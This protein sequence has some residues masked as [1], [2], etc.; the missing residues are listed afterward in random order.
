MDTYCRKQEIVNSL[1]HSV[2]ILFGIVSIPF[3]LNTAIEHHNTAGIIGSS[4]YGICYLM[5]FTSST[6]YHFCQDSSKKQVF[7]IF[8]HISIYFFIAGTYTPFLLVFMNNPLGR[9]LLC[10]LWGLTLFGI[11]WKTY[12]TGKYEI[13]STAV[14]VLMGWIMLVGGHTFFAHLPYQVLLLIIIGAGLYTVGVFFY[15]WD[16]YFYTH[17]VWHG[18]VLCAA[19]FHYVAVLLTVSA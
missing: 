10:I 4:V 1:T 7:K 18:F 14:Y 2:G 8:D 6:I 12:Y 3:L 19:V 5:A 13:V 9:T 11:F 15:I 16:K 17:A